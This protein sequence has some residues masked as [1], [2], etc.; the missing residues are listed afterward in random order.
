MKT[1]KTLYEW[2][3]DKPSIKLSLDHY[4]DDSGYKCLNIQ[5]IVSETIYE[6]TSGIQVV[7]ERHL[8]GSEVPDN[9]EDLINYLDW[10]YEYASKVYNIKARHK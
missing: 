5:M 2:I 6:E 10:M 7:R 4:I 1:P 9:E 3:F 8:N